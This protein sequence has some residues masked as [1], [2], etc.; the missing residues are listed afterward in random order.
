MLTRYPNA[1]ELVWCQEE[2]Q[3]QGAWYQ[4]RNR[5][6]DIAGAGRTVSYAGRASASA[7]ATGVARLHEAE[8]RL[9]VQSALHAAGAEAG[10]MATI[11]EALRSSGAL[12]AEVVIR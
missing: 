12:H 11:F 7:P 5:L 3:N 10:E 4:I 2:P 6:V 1:K 9:L 8:Q